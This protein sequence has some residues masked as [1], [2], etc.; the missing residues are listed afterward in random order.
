MSKL[1]L[2]LDDE[3]AIRE[4]FAAYLTVQGYRVISVA[5]PT[6]ALH[7]AAENRPDLFI[8]DLQLDEGDGFETI[9]QMHAIL[10]G[11]PVLI[12]TGVLID[13]QIARQSIARE[14]VSYVSKTT[15]LDKIVN[16]VRRLAGG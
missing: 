15:P 16:E 2:H 10:P 6:E 5:S 1:I 8:S 7:A 9:R 11:V 14:S 3:P 13:A 4:V 12:L